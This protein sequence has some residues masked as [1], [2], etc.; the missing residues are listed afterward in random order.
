M[1]TLVYSERYAWY[2]R[3]KQCI[4]AGTGCTPG[5]YGTYHTWTHV[6]TL[7]TSVQFHQED[8]FTYL[9]LIYVRILVAID[10]LVP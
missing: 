4:R 7:H 10:L 5:T 9:Y 2:M 8:K 6:N 3:Y 1:D